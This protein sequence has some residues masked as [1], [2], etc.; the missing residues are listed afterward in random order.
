MKKSSEV[1][2]EIFFTDHKLGFL[3]SRIGRIDDSQ[4]KN[5][6]RNLNEFII[7]KETYNSPILKTDIKDIV[8]HQNDSESSIKGVNSRIIKNIKSHDKAK[9]S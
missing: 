3:T 6:S 7:F 1:L 9:I 8:I 2:C 4:L 5:Y